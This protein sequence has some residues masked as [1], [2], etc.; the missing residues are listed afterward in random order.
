MKFEYNGNLLEEDRIDL[1]ASE[2]KEKYSQISREKA[3]EA[4]MLEG[5]I[6][7]KKTLIDELNRLYNIM[8]VTKDEKNIFLI[9]YSD[10]LN[11][12]NNTEFNETTNK[13]YLI[14]EQ[15]SNYLQKEADFPYA[16]DFA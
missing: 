1:V 6:S 12:L 8:F 14:A 10:F 5:K 11:I 3:K 2:I 4:A 13:Y 15:I 16:S 9:V 7:H